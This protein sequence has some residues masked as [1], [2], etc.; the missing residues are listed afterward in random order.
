MFGLFKKS[1]KEWLFDQPRNCAVFTLRQIIEKTV[2]ILVVYHDIDDHGWQFL[3]N[4]ETRR[5]DARIVGL[6]E[7]TKLDPTVFEVAKIEPGYHAWRKA[8]GESWNIIKT[9][10]EEDE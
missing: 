9:P 4:I 10:P 7:I 8:V 6:E 1:E 3:S 2:P 5:E